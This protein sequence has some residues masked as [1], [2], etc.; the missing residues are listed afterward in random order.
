[1]NICVKLLGS[2]AGLG[3]SGTTG[4]GTLS[5]LMTGLLSVCRSCVNS[6]GFADEAAGCTGAAGAAG[7]LLKL[8]GLKT[9]VRSAGGLGGATGAG[10]AGAGS[11]FAAG[12]AGLSAWKICVNSPGPEEAGLSLN[13][14]GG[15]SGTGVNA[16]GSVGASDRKRFF[17]KSSSG[18]AAGFSEPTLPNMPVALDPSLELEGFVSS[19]KGFDESMTCAP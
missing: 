5:G 18:G 16:G 12:A 8:T 14:T 2:A 11:T 4:G 6:P 19:N 9:L 3:A 7:G 15:C 1:L 10:A 13:A 17:R